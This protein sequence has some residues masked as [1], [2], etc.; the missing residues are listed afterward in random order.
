[1]VG[2][3]AGKSSLEEQQL[4]FFSPVVVLS[5]SQAKSASGERLRWSIFLQS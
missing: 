3:S 2:S 1:M 5:T 4:T